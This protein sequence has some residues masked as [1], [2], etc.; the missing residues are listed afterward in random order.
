MHP[1][2]IVLT[3]NFVAGFLVWI[4]C[5]CNAMNV[6]LRIFPCSAYF[7]MS[8]VDYVLN[9]NKAQKTYI[10]STYLDQNIHNT[11]FKIFLEYRIRSGTSS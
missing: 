6:T 8:K 5:L 11:P 4:L 2:Y 3:R 9:Y 7:L 10:L 1:S